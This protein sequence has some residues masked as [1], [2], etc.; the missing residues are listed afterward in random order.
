MRG[1]EQGEQANW[2]Y[3]F[4]SHVYG[5][6]GEAR[7]K[8]DIISGKLDLNIHVGKEGAEFLPLARVLAFEE[9]LEQAK[10]QRKARREFQYKVW[11]WFV[12]V[13]GLV[14]LVWTGVSF[15]RTLTAERLRHSVEVAQAKERLKSRV[16]KIRGLAPIPL[17]GFP[18][19]TSPVSGGTSS[20]EKKEEKSR[21]ARRAS[22]KKAVKVA[23]ERM[24]SSCERSQESIVKGVRKYLR[25]INSCIKN[26][27]SREEGQGLGAALVVNFVVRP[28]GR[29]LDFEIDK[30]RSAQ[31][32]LKNCMTRVFRTIRFARVGGTNCPV[33]LPIKLKKD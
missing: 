18:Q 19:A 7:L 26:Q 16:E 27:Q 14:L 8:E 31:V 10:R 17:A 4:G 11:G 12:M 24:V 20:Q 15:E 23:A 5:P 1:E 25:Q 13:V 2:L 28:T 29:V 30:P 3:R 21:V 9:C 33:S 22:S 32:G 6:V